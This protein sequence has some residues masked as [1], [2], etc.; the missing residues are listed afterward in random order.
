MLRVYV[1]HLSELKTFLM[2]FRAEVLATVVKMQ[3][4][5]P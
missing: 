3:D 4:N 5:H 2:F 1:V